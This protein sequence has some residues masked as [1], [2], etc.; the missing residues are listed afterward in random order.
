MI[1]S[2]KMPELRTMKNNSKMIILSALGI[3]AI[4]ALMFELL[5]YNG[6]FSRK[7]TNPQNMSG[8]VLYGKMVRGHNSQ[9]L[10]EA[11]AERP[12]YVEKAM[13]LRESIRPLSLKHKELIQKMLSQ[14]G[15]D[16]AFFDSLASQLP[17]SSDEDFCRVNNVTTINDPLSYTW[18][19]RD[20]FDSYE[21]NAPQIK[22]GRELLRFSKMTRFKAFHDYPISI[23]SSGVNTIQ[24]WMSGRI[25][26]LYQWEKRDRTT[27]V[28][29]EE[30]LEKKE[31]NVKITFEGKV[32]TLV[33]PFEFYK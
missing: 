12:K 5:L 11:I 4:I 28:T 8:F 9:D 18:D 10:K 23:S 16:P 14:T 19:V 1:L 31:E 7:I 21:P 2:I 27:F 17:K 26:E 24:I 25:T 15:D 3:V 32:I 29:I 22:N 30:I 6:V 13:K 20:P 33:E